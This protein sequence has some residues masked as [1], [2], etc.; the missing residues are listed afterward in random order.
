MYITIFGYFN[1]PVLEMSK[2]AGRVSGEMV[3]V[4][5]HLKLNRLDISKLLIDIAKKGSIYEIIL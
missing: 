5:F 3:G 4:M 1:L 2:L